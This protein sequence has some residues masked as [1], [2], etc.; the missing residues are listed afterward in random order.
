MNRKAS[1][2]LGSLVINADVTKTIDN[3][4]IAI[5]QMI[6]IARAVDM[7]AKVLILDEPTSSLDDG[8]VEKA[9]ELMRKPQGGGVGIIFVTH[10]WNRF[11][12]Y[13]I[14]SRC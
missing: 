8:E 10:S 3:Y 1:E 2:L 13:A 7:S 12:Q 6:A 9:F 4:S 14:K 11:M 5:Q